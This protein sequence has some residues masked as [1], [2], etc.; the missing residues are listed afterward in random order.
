MYGAD[1]R[2]FHHGTKTGCRRLF[3]EQGVRHP[4]G[5]ENLTGIGEV[6][7]RGATSRGAARESTRS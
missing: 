6:I 5:E 4:L 7:E 3:V 1:P 2:F